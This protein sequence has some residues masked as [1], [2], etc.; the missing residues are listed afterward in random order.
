MSDVDDSTMRT[1]VPPKTTVNFLGLTF[2]DGHFILV[3][4]MLS[5][6]VGVVYGWLFLLL[7]VALGVI[8]MWR[9]D[10]GRV[11]YVFGQWL[12][13]L[14]IRYRRR[15]VIWQA[16]SSR[17]SVQT[18]G[19]ARRPV[20]RKRLMAP[21]RVIPL[22]VV[23]LGDQIGVIYNYYTNSDAIVVTGDGAPVSSGDFAAQQAFVRQLAEAIKRIAAQ[24]GYSVGVSYVFRRRPANTASALRMLSANI[25]PDVALPEAVAMGT[26]KDQWSDDDYRS[27]AQ[28]YLIQEAFDEAF[29]AGGDVVMALTISIK[30]EG[31]VVGAV[32]GR[33]ITVSDVNRLAVKRIADSAII[34]LN[35]C[36]VK[37]A[38]V[39]DRDGVLAFLRGSWDVSK[40]AEFYDYMERR[41]AGF[42]ESPPSH[43]PR[44][45]IGALG[46]Y[47]VTD[48]TI[49][50]TFMTRACPPQSSAPN[51]FGQLHVIDAPFLSIAFDGE[52]V[53]STAEQFVLNKV[54]P[55]YQA[56]KQVAG[57]QYQST[58]SRKREESLTAREQTITESAYKQD[59]VILVVIS[60][61]F[62]GEG[63]M[64]RFEQYVGNAKAVL[65]PLAL[66]PVLIDGEV[67]L[68]QAALTG[69]TG[70]IML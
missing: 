33:S 4:V 50:A 47:L 14:W 24:Q 35:R 59:G 12:R 41:K 15:G 52:A 30:R 54:I 64:E 57:V 1:V 23:N 7:S 69:T 5:F 16:S 43:W 38:A 13:S 25:H 66:S 53:T 55:N 9:L 29:K 40:V 28:Q 36:G 70:L 17:P 32:K 19:Q 27:L 44:S 67:R 8:L 11:Y 39:L 20:R 45:R 48:D 22:Q 56:A 2:P 26:P 62:G 58:K 31:D 68:L 21:S 49:H 46:E 63:D 61:P 34:E 6:M 37:G 65:K 60:A 10:Y 42:D 18:R 3:L 51:W